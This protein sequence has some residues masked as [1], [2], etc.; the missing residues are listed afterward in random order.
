LVWN[1]PRHRPHQFCYGFFWVQN[2]NVY[3][4]RYA[5]ELVHGSIPE[6]LEIDHTCRNTR[7]VNVE[8]LEAVTRLENNRRKVPYKTHCP[9]GHPYD[10]TN[11]YILPSTGERQCRQCKAENAQ[12]QRKKHTLHGEATY[13][14]TTHCPYGHA[15]TD[16]N[17]YWYKGNKHCRTCQK[18]Q[19][20]EAYERRKARLKAL[21][22]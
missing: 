2:R 12:Q 10:E 6:G 13:Q 17:T 8:H 18:Q 7:C 3:A 22:D 16:D 9:H 4:H 19:S 20:H 15:Y 5:W 21:K 14:V 11:T 1:T